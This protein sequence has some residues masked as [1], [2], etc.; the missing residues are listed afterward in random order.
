TSMARLA[1]AGPCLSTPV[2]NM[3][4]RRHLC[5]VLWMHLIVASFAPELGPVVALWSQEVVATW[6]GDV[7]RRGS[8]AERSGG[9]QPRAEQIR[10]AALELFADR[11]YPATTMEE[12]GRTAGIRGPSIYRHYGSKQQLLVEIMAATMNALIA[13]QRQAVDSSS[14][15]VQQLRRMA[16]A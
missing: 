3:A 11:G 13:E 15:V 6:G 16:E 8:A 1:A 7:V 12:I 10:M 5:P 4:G 2:R 14:D 9:A